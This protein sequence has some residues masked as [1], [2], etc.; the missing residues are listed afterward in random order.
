[1]QRKGTIRLAAGILAFALPQ[2]SDWSTGLKEVSQLSLLT[3]SSIV[4]QHD[5]T[6]SQQEQAEVKTFNG[7][8]FNDG[9]NF[10]LEDPGSK[11]PYQLDDQVKAKEYQGKNVRVTGTLDAKNNLIHVQTIEEAV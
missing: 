9:D 3:S 4:D 11:T 7:R 10:V 1:M 2:V 8:I 5:D 6:Q